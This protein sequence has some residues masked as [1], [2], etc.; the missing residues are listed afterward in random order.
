M[1]GF[2]LS[3]QKLM[4]IAFLDVVLAGDGDVLYDC[5]CCVICRDR[6]GAALPTGQMSE[7][8][9]GFSQRFRHLAL[10]PAS[11]LWKWYGV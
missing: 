3:L 1:L 4:T 7:S 8:W 9:E 10:V 11:A 2:V 5:S 6:R